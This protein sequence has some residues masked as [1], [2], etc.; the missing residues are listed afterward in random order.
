MER[1]R[2]LVYEV[3]DHQKNAFL[4]DLLNAN[5]GWVGVVVFVRMTD[6]VHALALALNEAGI[7]NAAVHGKKKAEARGRVLEEFAAGKM[8][9]LVTTEAAV[10]G[11]EIEGMRCAVNYDFPELAADFMARGRQMGED[12][13]M[14]DFLVR[15]DAKMK[16]KYEERVGCEVSV[17][18]LEGFEHDLH[19]VKVEYRNPGGTKRG[20]KAKSKPLQNRKAK[21]KPK[22]YG[23]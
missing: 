5:E 9:V 2:N 6:A 15:R 19:A 11:R 20:A 21:W 7:S 8:R 22:K 10:R 18:E 4:V 23:R 12:G 16:K 13:V 1:E 3:F 14:V 17:S